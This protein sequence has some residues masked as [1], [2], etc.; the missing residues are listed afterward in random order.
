MTD[1]V[2]VK[3]EGLPPDQIHAELGTH[4]QVVDVALARTTEAGTV[5]RYQQLKY[6]A[7][8]PTI[9]WTWS[10]LLTPQRKNRPETSVLA[11]LAGLMKAVNFAGD[12]AIISNQPLSDS[13]RTE[14]ARLIDH[15]ETPQPA[16]T[17]LIKKL[18]TALKLPLSELLTFLKA[19]DL[20]GFA[21]ASRLS[22]ESDVIRRL[23]TMVDAD[24]RDDARRLHRRVTTLML[25]EGRGEPP[26]TRE[27]LLLWLG[28]GGEGILLPAPSRVAPT[29]PY[30]RRA[31]MADL[32][33]AVV[34]TQATPLRIHAGGGCGK[35]SMVCD[36]PALLPSGSA[37]FIYDCYGGGTF[38]NSDQKRHLPEHA[39]TQLGNEITA[40]FL[41]PFVIR[42][43]TSISVFESFRNRVAA[44][45]E[46]LKEQD[47]R[48]F[49]VLCFDAVDNAR[50]GAQHWK[51]RCFLDDLVQASGW[52]DN[53][54][55][56]VSCRTARLGDVGDGIFF[57]DFEVKSFDIEEVRKLVALH[58][59]SWDPGLAETF[60][61][62]TG[63][64]PRRIVY[65]I[66]GLP[67][68]N[69]SRAIER[70]M[71]KEEGIDPLF[72]KRVAEAG[73]LLGDPDAVWRTLDALGRL[74]RPIPEH[75]LAEIAGIEPRDIHDIA[76]DVGGIVERDGGWSFHD[77]D[78]EAFVIDR[79]GNGGE[80]LLTR[81][82]D[83]LMGL[84]LEDRYAAYGIAEVLV[85]AGQLEK[86]YDLAIQNEEEPKILTPLEW[87]FVQSRRLS[88]AIRCCREVNDI[89][90][91]SHL[92]IASTE[93]LQ[94][95]KLLE[96]LIIDNVDLSVRFAPDE[97][98]RLVM[99]N[100]EHKDRRARVRIEL[101]R[102][103]TH[104]CR[105]ET[106][107]AHLH[108][109]HVHLNENRREDAREPFDVNLE[110]IASEYEVDRKLCGEK[111][112][113]KRLFFWIPKHNIPPVL[114]IIASRAAGLDP[115]TLRN[116]ISAY[117][118]IPIALAP[119]MAAA[120]L[121]DSRITEPC[122]RIGLEQ[123]A[124]AES[125]HWPVLRTDEFNYPSIL[126]WP[127]AVLLICERA[128]VHADFVPLVGRILDHAFPKPVFKEPHD[129]HRLQS[130]AGARHSRA[131]V[132]REIVDGSTIEVASWFP[133]ERPIP[134]IPQDEMRRRSV[135]SHSPSP[136]EI[137]N[138]T[139]GET[140]RVF[141]RLVRAARVTLC[142]L[143]TGSLL[144]A[145]PEI[146]QIFGPQI[147]DPHRLWEDHAVAV[148][149]RNYAV[150]L[151]LAGED[152]A[153]LIAPL[154]Q[155]LKNRSG[156]ST[157]H[158]HAQDLAS[159][160][161]LMPNAHN[162]ALD[163]LTTLAE[164]TKK[165]ALSASE[166]VERI[167]RYARIALPL[168]PE[169]AKSL[170]SQ[171]SGAARTVDAEAQSALNAAGKI[172]TK[173]LGGTHAEQVTLATRLA[174]SAGA[175]AE[176]LGISQNFPWNEAAAWIVRANEPVGLLVAAR[177]QDEGIAPFSRTLPAILESITGLSLAQRLA[178]ATLVSE[179]QIVAE[180]SLSKDV[181][182][183]DWAIESVLKP[184][185]QQGDPNLFIK[186]F[187]ALA[188]RP[189][190]A[191]SATIAAMSPL[192]EA[193]LAWR[194][195]DE[196]KD[197]NSQTGAE[198]LWEQN[199][200][201]TSIRDE[202]GIQAALVGE[203]E[204]RGPDA[205]QYRQAAER[206]TRTALRIPF[207]NRALAVAG[208]SGEFG[209][210]LPA[211]LERWKTYPPIQDWIRTHL[212]GYIVAALR[213]LFLWS[214]EET[215]ILENLLTATGL[216]NVEQARILLEGIERE[217]E[218]I[219]VELLYAL[220]GLVAARAPA[221]DRT[222]LFD[223]LL[224]RVEGRTTHPPK[225][226]V[227]GL[228]PPEDNAE[229]VA[230]TI[231]AAMGDIDRRMRWRASHAARLLARS[232]D[233]AWDLLLTRF[234]AP[235]EP[236]F[237]DQP[238]YRYG[239]LEQ[240]MVTVQRVALENPQAVVGHVD[241]I[242]D[243]L[244]H[245]V[246]V[247]VREVGRS[248]LL[249]LADTGYL[250]LA[251]PTRTFLLKLN[252]TPFNPVKHEKRK[253]RIWG[254]TEN[255]KR[256]YLFDEIDAIPYWYSP[257]ASMFDIDMEEFLDR[258]E[259]W[260]HEKWGYQENSTLWES[261]P[262][263]NRLDKIDEL[264]SLESRDHGSLPT[265]E[266]LSYHNEWHAM[267]C[268]LGEL[269]AQK[270]LVQSDSHESFERWLR[271][272]LPTVAPYWLSDMRTPAPLEPR[273]WGI[274]PQ[275]RAHLKD[276][277]ENSE[278]CAKPW[279]NSI[280]GEAFENEANGPDGLVAAAAF[281][282]PWGGGL[283]TV[284][285]HSALV[286]P[287]TA[288]A[289]AQAL[290]NTRNNMCF[291][292]PDGWR[293]GNYETDGFR[294]EAWLLVMEQ[295]PRIDKFDERR[296]GVRGIPAEPFGLLTQQGLVFD[297]T[298]IAW[299]S[300]TGVP[301]L[302]IAQWGDDEAR[303]GNGWRITADRDFLTDLLLRSKRSLIQLVEISRPV[304][305]NKTERHTEWM[306][307]IVDA[308]GTL[309]QVKR[310]RRS[311]GRYLVRRER[312]DDSTDTLGRWILHRAAELEA[313]RQGANDADCARLERDIEA[314]CIA[315]R[316][317]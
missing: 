314:L 72:K 91:A 250:Q 20:S 183:P 235:D 241:L 125:T 59:P 96:K 88:L 139:L 225:T 222:T 244:R 57:T 218:R 273:F 175:V 168:D 284:S 133:P 311:L 164:E 262:R 294:L 214:Y 243:T 171:A 162:A 151:M 281:S 143:R 63:G 239:A 267:M 255:K 145:W 112:A 285:I 199:P 67:T 17:E 227:T 5:Y 129:L 64:N 302:K 9:D 140:V 259:Y 36:L 193:V 93:A 184:L 94:S 48:A 257:A 7:T 157:A 44:A 274:A 79:P 192:R 26:V 83:Y 253:Q 190:T 216:D 315:F 103:E 68:T 283:Q 185:A 42:R 233:R 73:G 136:E 299:T 98:N 28:V 55:I 309:T 137:W 178:L 155:V 217:G 128:I 258:L 49:L 60:E 32:V 170:F 135:W 41:T 52:P 160:L 123:L 66:E 106:A 200:C 132:L 56:V 54:R 240:L 288:H 19:W 130:A 24:A 153:G 282:L 34:A 223:S 149:L 148:L 202:A 113:F 245:E 111:E 37:V 142:A 290:A 230:R 15:G 166:R 2:S 247:V 10:R 65:A 229:C 279:G 254:Y 23:T 152:G 280:D 277:S 198:R 147:P 234:S 251:D 301:V 100:Q 195:A 21:A 180:V 159:T 204:K 86:L 295:E 194:E 203:S 117:R 181:K 316:H 191:P 122:L 95:R 70:L 99:T 275:E 35:T 120:I 224:Q 138:Q 312:L 268:V 127:E 51:E 296:G 300:P 13:V 196:Q 207:L 278:A 297:D 221:R 208:N 238:F 263:L 109:W 30:L 97:V 271:R 76:T 85:A 90:N 87:Q 102:Q 177:W 174:D 22:L 33:Q 266:R 188:S 231:F 286:S 313:L 212:P 104:N 154:H 150:H 187:D 270:P 248:L 69:V 307:H 39:F 317:R 126:A 210:A 81:A 209:Q 12:F 11:K 50:I 298:Q 236:L 252:R 29:T 14:V 220:T 205:D 119:L 291:A 228:V 3:V 211:I 256:K 4:G 92:L 232:G 156:R 82:A 206:L 107:R 293:H 16:D 105:P 242:L 219:P 163:L 173:G 261:E 40:K 265:I 182:F 47:K 306:L 260:L 6:S 131:F 305:S 269:I 158:T 237:A 121:A 186:M 213:S 46:L 8:D 310:E 189:E 58:Q 116:A 25:P 272:A 89:S 264:Y 1:V 249:G 115:D 43:S 38:R 78:F 84:R 215:E 246:H 161:A 75:I 53:V 134:R 27:T 304:A 141:S 165:A 179:E 176:S 101:A 303:H 289:L 18:T 124:T 62:L 110:D 74:P 292:L 144:T 80:A 169:L 226:R 118:W 172:A 201:D 146:E 61:N 197:G 167:A 308:A 276:Q 31:M 108:W 71:P 77:E 114:E 287:D 45:A